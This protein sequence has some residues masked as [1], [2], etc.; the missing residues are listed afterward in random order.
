VRLAVYD[1]LGREVT[2]LVDGILPAGTHRVTWEA[3]AQA[4]GV[5]FYKLT[6]GPH[7]QT[8]KLLLMK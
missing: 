7:S 8:K 6:A 2:T 4:G 5:Y 1:V 3:N